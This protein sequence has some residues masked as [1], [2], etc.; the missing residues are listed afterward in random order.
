MTFHGKTAPGNNCGN[1]RFKFFNWC[2]QLLLVLRRLSVVDLDTIVYWLSYSVSL[3]A[4]LWCG[5][6]FATYLISVH[7][8]LFFEGAHQFWASV[9]KGVGGRGRGVGWEV[10]KACKK[11]PE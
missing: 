9:A 4:F 6:I 8:R 7:F 2:N 10:A 5:L 1:P 11:C 3:L